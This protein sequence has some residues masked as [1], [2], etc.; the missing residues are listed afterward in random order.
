MQP[1]GLFES[2][3]LRFKLA[4]GPKQNI[5][6]DTGIH[7]G[8][9]ANTRRTFQRDRISYVAFQRRCVFIQQVVYIRCLGDIIRC[10]LTNEINPSV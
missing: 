8:S 9:K 5:I 6:P 3:D 1:Q 10:R 2:L 7:K 4:R